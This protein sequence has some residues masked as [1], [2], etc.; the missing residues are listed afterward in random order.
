LKT[1]SRRG[2]PTVPTTINGQLFGA[3]NG[4]RAY[5][6]SAVTGANTYSWSSVTGIAAGGQT[7]TTYNVTYGSIIQ[8]TIRVAGVNG[9]GTGPKK[10]I[11]VKGAPN[12]PVVTGPTTA[13][14]NT[15]AFNYKA[16]FYGADSIYWTGPTGSKVN[17]GT[18]TVNATNLLRTLPN[19]NV[20]VKFGATVGSVKAAAKN[21]CGT[22]L[23]TIYVVAPPFR[24]S[25]AI[26]GFV[27]DLLPNPATDLV[28]IQVQTTSGA[29]AKVRL[30][31]ITGQQMSTDVMPSTHDGNLTLP[32]F[33]LAS[34]MYLVEVTV[35]GQKMVKQLIK[36]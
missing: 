4:P 26:D 20:N 34:G 7:G 5:T 11:V 27:F 29:P 9:C 15:T 17:V 23:A 16:T 6:V 1:V 12:S 2:V 25:S 33:N 14:A 30:L 18:S 13:S 31:S 8:D 22:S 19:I 24:M 32:V 36:N 3:C 28:L 10:S 21:S 35:D